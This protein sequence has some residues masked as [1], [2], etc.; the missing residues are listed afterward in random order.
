MINKI[1][2]EKK[3]MNNKSLIEYKPSLIS[4]IKMFFKSLFG[5]KDISISED[6]NINNSVVNNIKEKSF[7]D[8]IK[9]E[10]IDVNNTVE[11]LNKEN[12]RKEFLEMID[13][14]REAL[15]KL[16]IAQLKKLDKYYD[17]IIEENQLKIKK[18]KG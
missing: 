16:S 13:G 17:R 11:K 18:A 6:K 9:I 2:E 7:L 12:E 10:N 1:L 5:K 15:N 4:K 8:D 3:L 14:N